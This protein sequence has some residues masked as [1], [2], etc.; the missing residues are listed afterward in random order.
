MTEET[1]D[2]PATEYND[3]F[4]LETDYKAVPLV[5]KADYSGNIT[6]VELN[7]E[8]PALIFTVQLQGNPGEVCSDG[9]TPVDGNSVSLMIWLPKPGDKDLSTPKG[10]MSKHQWKI[11]NLKENLDAMGISAPTMVAIREGIADGSFLKDNVTV[12]VDVKTYKG[13]TSNEVKSIVG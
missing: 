8:L 4:D 5:P 13:T 7:P 3:D 12:S 6:K 2:A 1:Q 9:E 10:N 11:N